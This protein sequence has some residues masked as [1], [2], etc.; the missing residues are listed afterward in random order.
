M[1]NLEQPLELTCDRCLREN[2]LIHTQTD[3]GFFLCDDCAHKMIF[4]REHPND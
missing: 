4:D 3:G 2:M 1:K